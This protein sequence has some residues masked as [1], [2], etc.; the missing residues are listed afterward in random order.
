MVQ[1]KL[2]KSTRPGLLCPA[3]DKPVP[4]ELDAALDF[5]VASNPML[6]LPINLKQE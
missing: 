1:L 5:D 6:A 3:I 2:D 4:I